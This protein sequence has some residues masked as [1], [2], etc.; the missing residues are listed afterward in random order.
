MEEGRSQRSGHF[1]PEPSRRDP[2][3]VDDFSSCR[4]QGGTPLSPLPGRLHRAAWVRDGRSSAAV[5]SG[6]SSGLI[7]VP[8]SVVLSS[9]PTKPA[10][11]LLG[12]TFGAIGSS[13]SCCRGRGCG[14]PAQ[15]RRSRRSPAAAPGWRPGRPVTGPEQRLETGFEVVRSKSRPPRPQT[16][17]SRARSSR[18][19]RASSRRNTS[20]LKGGRQRSREF[21]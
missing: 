16:R 1:R 11:V 15:R 10:R 2:A 4:R 8:V 19:L 13:G 6:V 5:P 12:L 21:S 20:T 7:Q 9:P 3:R 18:R 14:G 17:A